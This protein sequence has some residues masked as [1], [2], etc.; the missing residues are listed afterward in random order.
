MR[1]R[2]RPVVAVLALV[3]ALAALGAAQT[4]QLHERHYREVVK[5]LAA[6]KLLVAARGLGD[7]NFNRTVIVLAAFNDE[8][9]MGLVVNRRG[10]T[11]L[12]KL[13]PALSPT[14]SS[15]SQVF[16][17]GPVQRTV[18][19]AIVRGPDPPAGARPIGDSMHL[20]SDPAALERLIAS[21]APADRFHVYLGYSGWGPGQLEAE[22]AQGA[23][24]VLDGDA[25]VVFDRD[26][27]GTWQRQIVRTEGLS[28]ADVRRP[29]AWR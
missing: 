1:P 22:T 4:P 21:G 9:A 18:T 3:T 13:F 27:A 19:L 24:H 2:V 29:A 28:A 7:P 10:E 14:V 11:T 8:G 16:T 26:P 20:V 15:A 5:A 25:D 23:W 17:G 6:G 12:A